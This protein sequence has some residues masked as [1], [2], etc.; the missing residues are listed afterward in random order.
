MTKLSKPSQEEI[1]IYIESAIDTDMCV[2][3]YRESAIDTD[4]CVYIYI[5]IYISM[6]KT[7]P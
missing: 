2:C 3:I 1:G 4:M 6:L 7:L 5:Y